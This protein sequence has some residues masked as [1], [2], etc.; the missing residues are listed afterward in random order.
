MRSFKIINSVSLTDT[1][2]CRWFYSTRFR[3]CMCF[4][5]KYAYFIYIVKFVNL[6]LFALFPYSPFNVSKLYGDILVFI[7]DV[8][9]LGVKDGK[10]R[11]KPGTRVL[12]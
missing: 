12:E 10:H 1:E 6:R 2:Q 4:S 11:S 3:M 7:L 9:N 8:G 5:K